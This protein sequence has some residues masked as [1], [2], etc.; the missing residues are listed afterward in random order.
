MAR[1]GRGT[2]F[3][4][5]FVVVGILLAVLSV[6][7]PHRAAA[8]VTVSRFGDR[9]SLH[10]DS[11]SLSFLPLFRRMVVPRLQGHAVIETTLDA[12]TSGGTIT[13]IPVR[14]ELAGSGPLPI[15]ASLVRERGWSEAWHRWLAGQLILSAEQLHAIVSSSPLWREV[16]PDKPASQ[17]PADL[18]N[19]LAGALHPF[20]VV[21][22]DVGDALNPD[23]VRAAA[24]QQLSREDSHHRRLVLLGLDA[25]DWKLVD[26]LT[27]RGVMPNL[28]T[29]LQ[30]GAQAI[31]DVPPPLI[32]PV[33]WTTIGTGAP[34]EVHRVLDFLEADPGGGAPRPVTSASRKAPAIWEMAAAAGRTTAVIGWW[35]TFPAQAPPGGAVYSDRLTEQLLG[36]SAQTPGLADP[37]RAETGA[38]ELAVKAQDVTVDMLSPLAR[39]TSTELAAVKSRADAWDTPIGGLV[40]LVA[41]TRTVEN[42]TDHELARG[43]EIIFSYLEGTDIVGHLFGPYRPPAMRGADP[44]LVKRFGSVVDRYHAL[45]DAWIGRVVAKLNPEDTLV[46]VSDHG[47]AWGENRPHVPSGTH[48]AT[49]VMWHRPEGFFFAA[50][51]RVRVSATR[52]RLGVLDVGPSL[53]ALAG[54]RPSSEMPGHVPDWLLASPPPHQSPVRYSSLLANRPSPT[55]EISPGA[56]QEVLAKLRALGYIAGPGTSVPSRPEPEPT[57]LPSVPETPTPSFDRAEARRLNNLAIS[58][59]SEGERER[60]EESFKRA[61]A[62]DPTYAPAYYSYSTMLR[63]QLRLDEADKMFWMAVRLGVQEGELAV[64]RLALDY[65]ARGMPAKGRDVLAHGRLLFPDSATIWL[66]SGVFLG[67]QGDLKEAVECLRRAVQLAPDNPAAYR[68][69]AVALLGAGEKDE[70]RRALTRVL[71]LDPSDSAAR[72]QLEALGG[73]TP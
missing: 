21:R 20:T 34:P 58:Q 60:A 62:A 18:E 54:L 52:H 35:A 45:V 12:K 25:L 37:A 73:R 65:Q 26:D 13:A 30:H 17:P 56:Q 39:V 6:V 63:R 9:V 8:V 4:I 38:R 61:I 16:F 57:T 46:I 47:F 36:L 28:R 49:A 43:T 50:G 72:Q 51:S 23:L 7:P 48:T 66:N 42:I 24:L 40:K 29:L 15:S 11:V 64:V 10:P 59:A 70:A 1:P 27:V 14:I 71:E 3:F 31:E 67:D 53:L 69:L 33:V 41:A 55:V 32:S 22:C 2:F 68:N 5:G 44:A 19:L